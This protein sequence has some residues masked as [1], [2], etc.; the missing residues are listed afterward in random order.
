MLNFTVEPEVRNDDAVTEATAMNF[1]DEDLG[2]AS[3][4]LRPTTSFAD[5]LLSE[6]NGVLRD[7]T[8]LIS[9]HTALRTSNY[10]N[11]T[12][13]LF[14]HS[15]MEFKLD[16]QSEFGNTDIEFN[17]QILTSPRNISVADDV[18]DD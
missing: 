9:S 6:D 1:R 3:R 5:Y 17:E 14:T 18:E 8:A 15:N 16:C 13:D 10:P 4:L 11:D 12:S 2:I 7:D